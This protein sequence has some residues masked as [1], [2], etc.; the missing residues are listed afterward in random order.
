MDHREPHDYI[1]SHHFIG[2]KKSEAESSPSY[3]PTIFPS[4]Y[5]CRKN[6][7]SSATKR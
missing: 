4:M 6:N 5:K 2:G 3:A 1:C 7:E